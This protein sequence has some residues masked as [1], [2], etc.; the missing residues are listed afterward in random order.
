MTPLEL[1]QYVSDTINNY[2]FMDMTKGY[3]RQITVM[4]ENNQYFVQ[5]LSQYAL[6]D[7]KVYVL[8]QSKVVENDQQNYIIA[9]AEHQNN[10]VALYRITQNN[11]YEILNG[12]ETV[13]NP[14]DISKVVSLAE[15]IVATLDKQMVKQAEA[16]DTKLKERIQIEFE[17]NK[18]VNGFLEVLSGTSEFNFKLVGES[19]IPPLIDNSIPKLLDKYFEKLKIQ[20]QPHQILTIG[21]PTVVIDFSPEM[22]GLYDKL[23][24]SSKS[25]ID[26]LCTVPYDSYGGLFENKRKALVKEIS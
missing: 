16:V 3:G 20:F 2:L 14:D 6:K 26:T 22:A 7:G 23:T 1:A 4:I 13:L 21:I 12:R 11:V 25:Y 19:S 9:D 15:S 5:R 8:C 17:E 24:E 18:Q 10:L